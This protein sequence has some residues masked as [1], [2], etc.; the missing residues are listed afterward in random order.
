M[1]ASDPAA[2]TLE[3]IAAEQADDWLAALQRVG[4]YD[5]YDLPAYHRLAEQR[6]EGRGILFA[7]RQSSYSILLPL[8]LRPLELVDG[9]ADAGAGLTDASSVYGYSGPISSHAE[10][11]AEVIQS[12]QAALRH[13]ARSRGIVSIFSRLH[14]LRPD[15]SCLE[16]L[17]EVRSHGLT[18]SIDLTLSEEE[19]W[20]AYRNNHRRDVRKLGRLGF[21]CTVGQDDVALA[22]FVHLYHETMRRVEAHA[23][24]FF[25]TGYFHALLA[26][27]CF[28]LI[29][30]RRDGAPAAGALVSRCN[31]I[32]QYHLGGTSDA[33]LADAPIKLVFDE[34]RRWAKAQGC[35][36]F[37]LG[38]GVGS[39][40]DALFNFK[41]GFSDHRREFRTWRWIVDPER[42]EA[43]DRAR[44][45]WARASGLSVQEG[46][47]FPPY[48]RLLAPEA[49]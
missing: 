35:A 36:V 5:F 30:C 27:G 39:R 43:L 1:T 24:Y 26:M 29:L 15:H 41:A 49:V 19:Q 28:E 42:S 22:A 31:G 17:G 11:P 18:V 37:H 16:G 8:L 10:L 40:Q 34:A 46:E 25:D 12:F 23:D 44:S 14:P 4:T 21:D 7:F 20:S 2:P 3:I 48:R 45:Q 33:Y 6:G 38:G 32:S 47:F 13:E 9:L